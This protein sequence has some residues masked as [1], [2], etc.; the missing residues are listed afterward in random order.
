MTEFTASNGIKVD[1]GTQGIAGR[2]RIQFDHGN[3]GTT[4]EM[5]GEEASALIEALDHERDEELGRWRWPENPNFLVLNEQRNEVLSA[6]GNFHY[7]SVVVVEESSMSS[8]WCPDRDPN[9]KMGLGDPVSRRGG[10]KFQAAARAYFDA[11]PE[12]K[13]DW[14]DAQFI[15]WTNGA[16]LPQTAQRD[17]GDHSLGW[18]WGTGT[19]DETWYSEDALA[20]VIGDAAVTVLRDAS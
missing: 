9:S 18:W 3:H 19:N 2:R 1:S 4:I 14:A 7:R 6:Q 5:S 11:H 16:Y 13:R 8:M 17:L 20:K 12:Q 15:T 10:E